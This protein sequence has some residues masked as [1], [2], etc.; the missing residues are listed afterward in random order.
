MFKNMLK[1]SWLSIVRK[2]GRAVL[3][4]LL[5][6][7]MANLV[8][9]SLAIKSAVAE[10]M[11]YAKST[12]GGSVYLQ[13]DI[14]KLREQQ[15]LGGGATTTPG[16]RPQ[17]ERPTTS[18]SMVQSIA[19]SEYVKD[20]TY[21][22]SAQAK[23]SEFTP[24]EETQ[25]GGFGGMRGGGFGAVADEAQLESDISIQGINAYAFIAGVQNKTMKLSS[26]E[27]FDESSNDQAIISYDLAASNGLEVGDKI[28]MQNVYDSTAHPVTI[29]G[30]YDLTDEQSFGNP[31]NTVYMNTATAAKYLSSESYNDGDYNVQNVRFELT[32]AEHTD[33][34]IAQANEKFP[35]LESDNLLL[36][37]DTSAYDQ[38]V[39]PIESVGGFATTIFW[40][41][42]IASVAIISLIVTINVKDRRYE[43]GVLLSLGATKFNV[44]A[45][46]LVELLVIGTVALA[47]SVA[48]GTLVA[49]SM[50]EGLLAN[51]MSLSEQQEE[52]GFGRPGAGGMGRMMNNPGNPQS[53]VEAIDSINVNAT[54]TDFAL[55]FAIGYG[56]IILALILPTWNIVKYQPKT[57]LTG[58]E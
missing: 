39:G 22:I 11:N 54:P 33:A 15:T 43:M 19:D 29:I 23:A 21:S 42:V 31:A 8:L 16:A 7:A 53:D 50:S 57:I 41:V 4:A 56:V 48:T 2:P 24:I 5:L 13:A 28:T 9:S 27:Y 55:L 38:M 14:E 49:K 3:I 34:F 26:G 58:K 32:G 25:A 44:A 30:I 20:Y 10:S 45:Q 40:V 12:L 51:Q 18:L 47:A 6:F 36:S 46:I 35:N 17:I 1:R 52:Q 37:I